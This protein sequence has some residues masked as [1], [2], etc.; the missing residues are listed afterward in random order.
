AAAPP[1]S[2]AGAGHQVGHGWWP[3]AGPD[4][5]PRRRPRRVRELRVNRGQRT[6]GVTTVTARRGVGAPRSGG[7]RGWGPGRGGEAARSI[8]EAK[9][10]EG[11][12]RF[13]A[14]CPFACWTFLSPRFEVCSPHPSTD[15][16]GWRRATPCWGR[17][18]GYSA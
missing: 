3:Q 14:N 11:F 5:Q 8:L 2:A 9:S 16:P 17:S 6:L 7:A 18:W 13:V 10:R 12:G 1:G 15:A 4:P